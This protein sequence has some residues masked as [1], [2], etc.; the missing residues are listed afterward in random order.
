[1]YEY[2]S[3]PTVASKVLKKLKRY[4]RRAEKRFLI[5][6]QLS[7]QFK[8]SFGK[9]GALFWTKLFEQPV[10]K[11]VGPKLEELLLEQGLENSRRNR[12][13]KAKVELLAEKVLGQ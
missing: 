7:M 4:A 6:K 8:R 3:D 10:L 1:M 2:Y 5:I 13:Q 12:S 11:R 9:I